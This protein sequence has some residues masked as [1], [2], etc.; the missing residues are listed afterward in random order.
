MN[1]TTGY[2][3]T[4]LNRVNRHYER[5]KY[6]KDVIFPIIDEALICHVGIVEGGQPLVI[7]MIHARVDDTLYLHGAVASRL[8]KHLKL[9]P[10]VCITITLLD[11]IVLARSVFNHSLNYRSVAVFGHGRLVVD[12]GEKM[13][14]LEAITQQI[15]RGRWADARKPDRKEMAATLVVAVG[16]ET[17]S[18]KVRSGPPVDDEEDLQY[19]TWAGVLPLRQQALA[20]IDAPHLPEHTPVPEYIAAY[21]RLST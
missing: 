15:A 20:P 10:P 1:P 3:P 18:A 11:G 14:A 9:G 6:D 2:V 5:G 12:D 19:P 21:Q 4:D 17:A 13:R 8:L 7:P 16:I